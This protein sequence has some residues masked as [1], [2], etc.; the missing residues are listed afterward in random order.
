MNILWDT[1]AWTDFNGFLSNGD[2]KSYKKIIVLIDDIIK[3]GVATGIG[4]PEQLKYDLSDYYS[5]QIN[6]C[7]RL[8][9][10]I[11]ENGD[12][13]IIQCKTHYDKV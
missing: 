10:K 2:K 12:L 5:R 3:N 11:N 6:E 7:D 13:Q 1:E 4:K 9:Y 8:V